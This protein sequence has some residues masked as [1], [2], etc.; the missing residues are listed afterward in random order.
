[1]QSGALVAESHNKS[2]GVFSKS[3]DLNLRV[4][5]QVAGFYEDVVISEAP[6][7]TPVIAADAARRQASSSSST[8]CG[9]GTRTWWP[10][11]RSLRRHE[12]SGTIELAMMP[13][14]ACGLNELFSGELLILSIWGALGPINPVF[15]IDISPRTPTAQWNCILLSV[16][17]LGMLCHCRLTTNVNMTRHCSV[18][19]TQ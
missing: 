9:S 19:G 11:P 12:E 14:A 5:P 6:R 18:D 16:L 3:Q 1:V 15:I 2:V 13:Y 10:V 4:F 8:C 17:V 7:C